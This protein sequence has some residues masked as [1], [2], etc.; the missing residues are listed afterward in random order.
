MNE[1]NTFSNFSRLKPNKTKC[2]IAGMGVLSG[3]QVALCDIKFVN[4]INKTV[5]I[6]GV[7]FSYN[8]NLE[9]DKNFSKHIVNIESVL[10]LWRMRQLTSEERI[11]AFKSSAIFKVIHLVLITKLLNNTFDLMYKI[12]KKFI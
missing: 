6:V 9:E 2:E 12:Q 7:H 1:L 11:T 3:F 5:K 4:L 10:K 8:K